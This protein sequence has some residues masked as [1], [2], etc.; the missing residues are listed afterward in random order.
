M[1]II[2]TRIKAKG[3]NKF[4]AKP[5]IIEKILVFHYYFLFLFGAIVFEL[6]N[7]FVFIE[8]R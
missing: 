4:Y 8:L 2:D 5:K 3:Q 7:Y 6:I 1:W